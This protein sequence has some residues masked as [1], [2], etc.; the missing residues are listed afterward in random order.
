[1][2]QDQAMEVLKMGSNVFLTGPA[3]SGKTFVLNKYI[4]YLK[5]KKIAVGVTASTGIAATHLSGMTIHS[6]CGIGIK[7]FLYDKDMS[8]ILGKAYLKKRFANTNVLIIDEV[9]MLHAYRLD[10]VDR[11]CKAFKQNSLPFG[12]MQVIMCGDFFQLPPVSRNN[13]G[14]SFVYKSEIWNNMDLKICYL[15]EQHRQQD[16]AFLRVLSDIR[17]NNVD[18]D[19]VNYLRERYNQEVKGKIK[20]TRLYT[21]N[22]DVDA[23]NEMELSKISGDIHSYKTTVRGNKDLVEFLHKSCLAPEDLNIKNGAVVMFVKNNYEKG[24]VNGTLGK[25]IGFDENDYPIVETA[26][27]REIIAAPTSWAIE[28]DGSVKAE[29]CQIPL[30]LAWAITIHKSQGMS[31]DAAEIDLSKSF[32]PGMGY[33]ALSRARTLS[34]MKLVGINDMALRVNPE[35]LEMDKF[36]KSI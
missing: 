29:I 24:Y 35:V 2:T 23:I 25:V 28:E 10:M 33:V 7:D 4:N 8:A 20:P 16:R 26:G 11:I 30:R 36:F 12:G 17:T 22:A 3:G 18:E 32:V 14:D 21:H 5:D 9:S 19:T 27:G 13:E 6:W 34:G 31:L 15:E 1:M